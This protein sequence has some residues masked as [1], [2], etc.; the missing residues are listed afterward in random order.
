MSRKYRPTIMLA[1]TDYGHDEEVRKVAACMKRYG[2][3]V[4]NSLMGTLPSS[5]GKSN[6]E[7]CVDAVADSDLFFGI[8]HT[9]YG[10]GNIDGKN[11]TREEFRKAVE[12]DKQRWGMVD[13][14]VVIARNVINHLCLV[15]ELSKPKEQRSEVSKLVTMRKNSFLDYECIG[16]YDEMIQSDRPAGERVGNWIQPYHSLADILRYVKTNLYDNKEKVFAK[17][18]KEKGL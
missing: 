8:I 18:N 7:N 4:V 17:L 10:S 15:S 9:D 1:S 16:F 13:E 14:V 3:R 2:Y 5:S 11:I 6:M 12:L